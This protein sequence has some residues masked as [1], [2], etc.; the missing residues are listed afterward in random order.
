[1]GAERE[2]A[3]FESNDRFIVQGLLGTGAF[4]E[5]YLA[6]DSKS[7]TRVAIKSLHRFDPTA[8]AL[9]KKEFRAL[10]DVIHP[11]LVQFF[12]LFSDEGRWYFTM[13]YIEGVDFLKYVWTD[14]QAIAEAPTMMDNESHH[15]ATDAETMIQAAPLKPTV[16]FGSVQELRKQPILA[17][18]NWDKIRATLKQLALGVN[19]LH[20]QDMLHRDLKP[21]NV[22]VNQEGRVT[23]LD[24]GLVAE[25]SGMARGT[26]NSEML[27]GTPVYMSPEQASSKPLTEASDWYSVGVM[28]FEAMVGNPPFTGTI[29]A[30]LNGKRY[31]NAPKIRDILP[32]APEDLASLCQGLLI[33][34]PRMRKTGTDVLEALEL[35]SAHETLITQKPSTE[36]QFV[37]RQRHLEQLRVIFEKTRNGQLSTVYIHGLSGMGKSVL[38]ERY[39]SELEDVYGAVILRGRCYQQESVPY[40]A[41]D[42]LIDSLARFLSQLDYEETRE[43][44]PQE[45]GALIRLFP[46]LRQVRLFAELTEGKSSIADP[47]EVQ[48]RAFRGLRQ[49]L[50][51]LSKAKALVLFIDDLQW[52]DLDSALLLEEV[53]RPPQPSFLLIGS[54]RSD[55]ADTSPFLRYVLGFEEIS[56]IEVKGLA[57][58]EVEKLAESLWD[59]P[60]PIPMG[61]DTLTRESDGSP[62]FVA[63]L[64][65]FMKLT[66]R[67]RPT[68]PN[69]RIYLDEM[70]R[71]R[72]SQLSKP[73]QHL[74]EVIALAGRPLSLE[75][76]Q[77][78]V[79]EDAVTPAELG[80]LRAGHLIRARETESGQ[81]IE[82]YHDRIR[83]SVI[84]GLSEDRRKMHCQSLATVLTRAN[85][86]D[87][88]QL[89]DYYFGAGQVKEAAEYAIKAADN[90]YQLLAF[91]RAARLYQLALDSQI[92]KDQERPL[93]VQLGN[94]LA[95]ARRG[96]EGAR[97]YLKAAELADKAQA[98]DLLYRAAH[99][100]FVTGYMKEGMDTTR[101]VLSSVG[102]TLPDYTPFD[103]A[104]MLLSWIWYRLKGFTYVEK[105]QENV[106]KDLLLRIDACWSV[107]SAMNSVDILASA[108]FCVRGLQLALEAGEPSRVARAMA[109]EAYMCVNLGQFRRRSQI[110]R[111]RMLIDQAMAIAEKGHDDYPIGFVYF[112][113]GVCAFVEGRFRRGHEMCEEAALILRN[114]CA[115]IS[116]ELDNAHCFSLWNLAH[117]GEAKKLCE[118]V[119]ELVQ[120]AHERKDL[121]ALLVLGCINLNYYYLF[122]D[123][124]EAGSVEIDENLE[125]CDKG[126]GRAAGLHIWTSFV[127]KVDQ[128]LYLGQ[129]EK[130][131]ELCQDYWPQMATHSIFE[132]QFAR[133]QC[134]YSR[135]RCALAAAQNAKGRAQKR[136]LK[137]VDRAVRSLKNE[138]VAHARALSLMLA[139][140]Q[141]FLTGPVD[142]AVVLLVSAERSL[143][144]VEMALHAA[145]CRCARGALLGGE[146]GSRLLRS[147]VDWMRGQDIHN[148][149]RI[150]ALYFLP[151]NVLT[152]S[153][154]F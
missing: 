9:F 4:G 153:M 52:G 7:G 125:M 145:V 12:E 43:F 124:I 135:G 30:I 96:L 133:V 87:A 70:I 117:M 40:K 128:A 35:G 140:G 94:A 53:L 44:A 90:A 63:E 91:D 118:Q 59:R 114:R 56:Q 97:V 46:V 5:V 69:Q 126:V 76:V 29:Q 147:G 86:A 50:I 13:E 54:Y 22:M 127:I 131:W 129:G 151:F 47:K 149:Q 51:N 110:L 32:S 106:S 102:M 1:M 148:F 19:A 20:Q 25:L 11:N 123:D 142:D 79:P 136:L 139:A 103:Q 36:F 98:V 49:L 152:E 16:S 18:K 109:A 38:I 93:L 119:P 24:F 28:L 121:Y 65:R 143:R 75:L 10:S 72:V 39:L 81:E 84:N 115:G 113:S 60:G 122:K 105:P 141:K 67:R 107:A 88:E 45:I 17:T 144:D 68:V 89:A 23:L 137:D 74:L 78:A 57:R 26:E 138:P 71:E 116:W 8:L 6:K 55:E 111:S 83:E 120:E 48:R 15:F 31:K 62:F 33:R 27:V 73:A 100:F 85:A 64:I 41:W 101:R 21:T 34:D 154:G 112:I 132:I 58:D 3:V 2:S 130:A 104:K 77:E 66:G 134:W 108:D 42:P 146:E 61:I 14:Y 150:G 80:M 82:S 37:G 95:N 99:G 92:E